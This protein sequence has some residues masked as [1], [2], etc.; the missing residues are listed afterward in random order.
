MFKRTA[1]AIILAF[2]ILAAF[3]AGVFSEPFSAEDHSRLA[4]SERDALALCSAE[5][6]VIG[7][8]AI[9]P[10]PRE[11]LFAAVLR[12][13]YGDSVSEVKADPACGGSGPQDF[14]ISRDGSIA[15]L[16]P[17]DRSIKLYGASGFIG[18][19]P[20]TGT[21]YPMQMAES[22]DSYYV[23]DHDGRVLR[24]GKDRSHE[25][26][27]ELAA[28]PDNVFFRL[29]SSDHG[30]WLITDDGSVKTISG[31]CPYASFHTSNTSSCDSIFLGRD[32]S[33]GTYIE[34][35]EYIEGPVMLAEATV[36]RFDESGRQTGVF[37]LRLEEYDI[38]SSRH[39]RI[40]EDGSCYS[41]ACMDGCAAV[42]AVYPGSEYSS[43]TEELYALA[44]LIVSH[45]ALS[46]CESS[47]PSPCAAH[48]DAILSPKAFSAS[49]DPKAALGF[50]PLD[51]CLSVKKLFFRVILQAP[52]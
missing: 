28:D 27:V 43:R 41:I 11:A 24:F 4:S 10:A 49:T 5:G 9:G 23:L 3:C 51:Y 47:A 15:I 16:D 45:R 36:T 25:P 20:L 33:G 8:P 18:C 13:P 44:D 6:R 38:P 39:V 48:H 40:L 32:S 17:A 12:I 42:F 52:G 7:S 35:I 37:G 50:V 30:V 2:F 46:A 31:K 22:S 19:F 14:L 21:A 34:S 26:V 29:E 1:S